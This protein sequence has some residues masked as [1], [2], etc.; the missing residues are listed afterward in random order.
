MAYATILRGTIAISRPWEDVSL[1]LMD[2]DSKSD[3][4]NESI[5]SD[6]DNSHLPGLQGALAGL[7]L[8]KSGVNRPAERPRCRRPLPSVFDFTQKEIGR[9]S[10]DVYL[11]RPVISEV[12]EI[13]GLTKRDHVS[14][15]LEKHLNIVLPGRY[16]LH[17]M[18]LVTVP[19]TCS[20]AI[21]C[22]SM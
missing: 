19:T 16:Y 3:R 10:S 18:S 6:F 4:R 8:N 14:E 11:R 13:A 1:S 22:S 15:S 9:E 2:P 12:Y 21:K 5:P 20:H 17:T 7:S